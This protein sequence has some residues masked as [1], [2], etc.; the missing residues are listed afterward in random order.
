[1]NRHQTSLSGRHS[2]VVSNSSRLTNTDEGHWHYVDIDPGP[3]WKRPV[4][5]WVWLAFGP[6]EVVVFIVLDALGAW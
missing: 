4:P 6:L 2:H 5:V 1:M 3:W